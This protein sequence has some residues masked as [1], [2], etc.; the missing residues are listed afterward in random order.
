MKAAEEA[1]IEQYAERVLVHR[2]PDIT[3]AGVHCRYRLFEWAM[4]MAL[5]SEGILL[6][7]W[8]NVIKES[9]FFPFLDVMSHATI[10]VLSFC[11]G[12]IRIVALWRNG[13]WLFWGPVARAVGAVG[14][15]VMLAAFSIA[16]VR[17]GLM[18]G[19]SPSPTMPFFLAF[20][21]GELISASR[22]AG[23]VRTAR[24]L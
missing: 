14:G 5:F 20:L 3:G 23:D 11:F 13:K 1:Q 19:R 9:A 17:H 16:L 6:V 4:A 8:P 7:I 21:G 10:A 18:M 12:G 15:A 24:K 2:L 22:A